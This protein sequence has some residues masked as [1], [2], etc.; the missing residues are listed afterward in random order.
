MAHSFGLSSSSSKYAQLRTAGPRG[1]AD[2]RRPAD[3]P[4]GAPPDAHFRVESAQ[5]H[6]E[7][8]ENVAQVVLAEACLCS[9]R[10]VQ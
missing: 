10:P 5:Q 6:E 4:P 7:V 2:V 8:S 1:Q 3:V 9:E